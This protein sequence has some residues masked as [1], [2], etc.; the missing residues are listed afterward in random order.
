MGVVKSRYPFQG[1]NHIL[2]IT[3]ARIVKFLTHVISLWSPYGIGQTIIFLP[4]GFFP[5]SSSSSSSL[6]AALRAA[7]ACRY[8]IYSEADFELFSPA[9]ATRCTDGGEIWHG[10]GAS[11]TPNFTPSVQ[12]KGVG[13]P[14]LKF[15]LRFDRN[16][17]YKRLAGA[18]LLR[19]YHKIRSFST[20]FQVASGVKI[21]W[22][23]LQGLWSYG[24]FKLRGSDC[25]QIFSAP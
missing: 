13:P 16:V 10:G 8:L 2:G 21:L 15:L 14:K 20:S 4:C 11:S 12:R 25:T 9:G 19:D 22:N 7:Q 18:Y 17:Q 23:L 5:S 6:P 1:P 24:G 3:E